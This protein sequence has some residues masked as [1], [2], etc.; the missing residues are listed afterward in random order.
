MNYLKN[1][2]RL[3]Q[4]EL[5]LLFLVVLAGSVVRITG[6]GMGCPDWPKCYGLLIPPTEESQVTW[7]PN[8]HYGEGQMIVMNETIFKA[9]SEFT[10]A[11]EY[12]ANNWEKYTKHDYAV[13]NATHTWV[14]YINRLASTLAGIPL[15][16]LV[17]YSLK[18]FRKNKSIALWSVAAMIIIL[19]EAWLGKLVVD[20][21]LIPNQITI[22]MLGALLALIV[23]V[24]IIEKTSDRRIEG[25]PENVK[26]WVYVLGGLFFMQ[27]LLG[28]QVREQIDSIYREMNGENRDLWV[29]MLDYK[30]LIHRSFSWTSLAMVGWIF[31]Q[32]RKKGFEIPQIKIILALIIF[33][34]L[35][36]ALLY[37]LAL[38]AFLQPLHLLVSAYVL[39]L[40][41]QTILQINK[42][43][44]V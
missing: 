14:E 25:I 34:G 6:S 16:L 20:G 1:I 29:G 42:A 43:E 4:I 5:A 38:P 19:F 33:L 21:N 8:T 3:A 11:D 37:Y 28:T 26:T 13:F 23:L 44:H 18:N 27:M 24:V 31:Y 22:H 2:K 39:V 40:I 12:D 10:S 30:V 7:H 32:G 9:T 35:S 41:F 17:V 36:G 15:L